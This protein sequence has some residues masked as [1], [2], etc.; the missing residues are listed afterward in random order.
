AAAL[1]VALWITLSMRGAPGRG[2]VVLEATY[3]TGLELTLVT[4]IAVLFSS[5]STPVLSALYTLGLYLVGVWSDDLRQFAA[6]FTAPLGSMVRVAADLAPNLPIFNMRTLAA[7]GTPTSTLH[8]ALATGYAF[9]YVG[10]A[11]SLAAAAFESR[12]FK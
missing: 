1:G 2:L 6:H 12:D 4:A 5:L 10:C 9:V 11:L 7:A 8:L 3:L